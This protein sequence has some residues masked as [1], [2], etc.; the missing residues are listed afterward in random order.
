VADY[1]LENFPKA[2]LDA[3]DDVN[4][5]IMGGVEKFLASFNH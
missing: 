3:L 5:H 2:D 1:V 4:G